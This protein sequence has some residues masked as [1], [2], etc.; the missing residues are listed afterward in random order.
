MPQ[1]ATA[2]PASGWEGVA[3]DGSASQKTCPATHKGR[4]V[5]A[6]FRVS[7]PGAM[8]G[9]FCRDAPVAPDLERQKTREVMADADAT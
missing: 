3:S 1:K 5:S 7:R 8:R 6:E 2:R 4:M 9:F